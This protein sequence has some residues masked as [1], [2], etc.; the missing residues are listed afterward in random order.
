MSGYFIKLSSTGP[1]FW[2]DTMIDFPLRDATISGL[3]ESRDLGSSVALC[4]LSSPGRGEHELPGGRS[5]EAAIDRQ[6]DRSTCRNGTVTLAD[7]PDR[8]TEPS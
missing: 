5:M 3:L 7:V 6:R 2:V 4:R 8:Q 1:I